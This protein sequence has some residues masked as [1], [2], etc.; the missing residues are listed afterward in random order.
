V[1]LQNFVSVSKGTE[2][3][4]RKEVSDKQNDYYA[5]FEGSQEFY[6][7]RSVRYK[8]FKGLYQP[9]NKKMDRV[10]WSRTI[11]KNMVLWLVL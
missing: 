11:L 6:I 10:I 5:T 4:I 8:S 7:A 3:I 9:H 2:P 1:S